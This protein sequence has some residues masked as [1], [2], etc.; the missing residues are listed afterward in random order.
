MNIKGCTKE[1]HAS[2]L[3]HCD[4]L[5]FSKISI[6]PKSLL[7]FWTFEDILEKTAK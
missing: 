2:M 5:V 1:S 6:C 7:V 4:I 3:R